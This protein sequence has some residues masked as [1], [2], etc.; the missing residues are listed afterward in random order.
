MDSVWK[1]VVASSKWV[2]YMT[3]QL[4]NRNYFRNVETRQLIRLDN[5]CA[6]TRRQEKII[7]EFSPAHKN[8]LRKH[9]FILAVR[10]FKVATNVLIISSENLNELYTIWHL[11]KDVCPNDEMFDRFECCDKTLSVFLTYTDDSRA[12]DYWQPNCR[13]YFTDLRT[14]LWSSLCK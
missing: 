2:C 11:E 12:K 14:G 6:R 10:L 13:F 1:S 7:V 8:P 5:K 3:M 4:A 9:F